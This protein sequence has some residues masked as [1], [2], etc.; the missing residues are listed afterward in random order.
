MVDWHVCVWKGMAMEL[1]CIMSAFTGRTDENL[2]TYQPEQEVV[3]TSFIY[4]PLMHTI[5]KPVT[6]KL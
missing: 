1:F 3:F 5:Y 2:V 4:L 6:L